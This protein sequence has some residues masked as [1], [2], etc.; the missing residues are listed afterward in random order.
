MRQRGYELALA[1]AGVALDPK[2]T[3]LPRWADDVISGRYVLPDLWPHRPT[4]IMA[5]NDLTAI[6]VMMAAREMDVRIPQDVSLVGFDDIRATEY[7]TPPLTTVHQPREAMGQA[8]MQMTLDLLQS[9]TVRN[10]QLTCELVIRDS[11]TTQA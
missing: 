5:Y 7:V 2:L 11:T 4:A 1:E 9:K 6:G 10:R 8:A 3:I